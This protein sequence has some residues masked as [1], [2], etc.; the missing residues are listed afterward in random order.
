MANS[1]D[2]VLVKYGVSL[3]KEEQNLVSWPQFSDENKQKAAALKK[4]IKTVTIPEFLKVDPEELSDVERNIQRAIQLVYDLNDKDPPLYKKFPTFRSEK[5]PLTIDITTAGKNKQ[6]YGAAFGQHDNRVTFEAIDNPDLLVLTLAHELKH[7]EQCDE[8]TYEWYEKAIS[9][10]SMENAYGWHEHGFIDETRA[11]LAGACAYY[12]IFGHTDNPRMPEVR[13]YEEVFKKY[14]KIL[15]QKRFDEEA[16]KAIFNRLLLSGKYFEYYKDQYDLRAPI[17]ET[18]KGLDHI[19][20][21]FHLPQ[22]LLTEF[23]KVPRIAR[24]V[25]GK[26]RQAEKNKRID[27]YVSLLHEG[28]DKNEE[29]PDAWFGYVCKNGSIEQIAEAANLKT[30]GNQYLFNSAAINNGVGHVVNRECMQYLLSLQRD[31]KPLIEA[32][33]IVLA[34]KDKRTL[35]ELKL[36]IQQVQNDQQKMPITQKDCTTKYGSNSLLGWGG[37]DISDDNFENS[38]QMLPEVLKLKGA[39]GAPL[40]TEK[41]LVKQLAK[42][43]NELKHPE[44]LEVLFRCIAD[45]NGRLPFER[46]K[47]DI[48]DSEFE[49]MNGQNTLLHGLPSWNEKEKAASLAKLPILMA[50]KGKDGKPIISQENIKHFSEYSPLAPAVKAYLQPEK[51]KTASLKSFF[52]EHSER[53]TKST[54]QEKAPVVNGQDDPH[55]AR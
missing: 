42:W 36:F 23:Q 1:M 43:T 41:Q 17:G 14:G 8:D 22:S 44:N 52:A 7:A 24:T 51:K 3:N 33:T 32:E 20:E 11:Y 31:E 40:V 6:N 10:M 26:L 12:R 4:Q 25:N 53:K 54:K 48:Q 2:G 28:I 21:V 55:S 15:D 18:D 29:M 47:F 34:L 9:G 27:E 38:I 37:L 30:K 35:E 19:P 39:D 46:E 49:H 45:E 16:V 50:L 5:N 13:I